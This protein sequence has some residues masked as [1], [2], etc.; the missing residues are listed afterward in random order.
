MSMLLL[1]LL[2][3]AICQATCS[4]FSGSPSVMGF[5]GDPMAT[6][7]LE[8]LL[9]AREQMSRLR[10]MHKV[11]PFALRPALPQCNSVSH[12]EMRHTLVTGGPES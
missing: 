4:A 2:L 8:F 7:V 11:G 5:P 6:G 3:S 12:I 1:A 10:L 9:L